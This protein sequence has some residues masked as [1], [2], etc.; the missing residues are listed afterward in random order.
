MLWN[1]PENGLTQSLVNTFFICPERLRLEYGEGYSE[2]KT[3]DHLQFGNVFHKVVELKYSNPEFNDKDLTRVIEEEIVKQLHKVEFAMT[4]EKVEIAIERLH[5]M[6]EVTARQYF[7]YYEKKD[8]NISWE[9]MEEV[10]QVEC[11][12]L[13]GRKTKLNGKKDGI[14]RDSKGGKWLFE[15]KTKGD[16]SDSSLMDRLKYDLQVNMYIYAEE[17]AT[18]ERPIGVLYNLVK[19]PALRMKVN[20]NPFTF[21]ARCED[22]I[23]A[24]P[25][26]YFRR[27]EVFIDEGEHF[28]WREEF[29]SQLDI[30]WDWWDGKYRFKNSGACYGAWGPCKF[31]PLCS[32]GSEAQ[33]IKR[34]DVF[35]ELVVEE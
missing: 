20:E 22:D 26:D 6:V 9:S 16:I 32:S 5:A 11:E 13:S 23:K 28:K 10:F 18:G 12:S 21:A 35:P 3:P 24:L 7:K 30:I 4:D 1:L 25:S 8:A 33:L 27:Y 17:L 2:K 34:T 29:K 15:T 19:R 31:I 14:I